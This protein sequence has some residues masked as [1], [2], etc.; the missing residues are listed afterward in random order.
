MNKKKVLLLIS[1]I[2][3]LFAFLGCTHKDDTP[4]EE[5]L[6]ISSG[7]TVTGATAKQDVDELITQESEVVFSDVISVKEGYTYGVFKDSFGMISADGKVGL[8][9]GEGHTFYVIIEK[10]GK[11]FTRKLVI[12]RKYVFT[13]SYD[14]DG[15]EGSEETFKD[16]TVGD[17]EKLT[18]PQEKPTKE[19]CTFIGWDYDFNTPIKSSLTISALWKYDEAKYTTK[20]LLSDDGND[21][22]EDEEKREEKQGLISRTVTMTA[23]A[24][25]G[26]ILDKNESTLSGVVKPDGTLELVAKYVKSLF[27]ESITVNGKEI[28]TE[29]LKT[30]VDGAAAVGQYWHYGCD[31]G[32]LTDFTSANVY[33]STD[34]DPGNNYQITKQGYA[35]AMI[36]ADRP[37]SGDVLFE[38]TAD[39]TNGPD[40]EGQKAG[41]A[42]TDG[43]DYLFVRTSWGSFQIYYGKADGQSQQVEMKMANKE[44][45]SLGT[46]HGGL[47]DKYSG[48]GYPNKAMFQ[49]EI[50]KTDGEIAVYYAKVGEAFAPCIIFTA[51]GA[52][53]PNG[54]ALPLNDTKETVAALLNSGNKILCGFGTNPKLCKT[55]YGDISIGD[56]TQ[57]NTADYKIVIRKSDNNGATWTQDGETETRQGKVGRT[58]SVVAQSKEGYVVYENESTLSGVVT[59]DGELTLTISYVRS[60]FTDSVTVNDKTVTTNR[61]KINDTTNGNYQYSIA[62]NTLTDKTLASVNSGENG[63]TDSM[64]FANTKISDKAVFEFSVDVSAAEGEKGP[65]PGTNVQGD[66]DTQRAGFALTDGT[67]YLY[68]RASYTRYQVFYSSGISMKACTNDGT[69]NIQPGLGDKYV[70]SSGDHKGESRNFANKLW[71]SVTID[72]TAKEITVY[73]A[74]EKGGAYTK[75]LMLTPSGAKG[76]KTDDNGAEISLT[77]HD[78]AKTTIGKI[79]SANEILCGF[80]TNNAPNSY[81]CNTV[82]G[83]ISIKNVETL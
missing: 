19:Y 58:V 59:A 35:S 66:I 51:D 71:F 77:A 25:N 79:L 82:F 28:T 42:L 38:F 14:L 4:K 27:S 52:K 60:L 20:I 17:G 26:Y 32:T 50:N 83:D 15:G 81:Q 1:V 76:Y 47:G 30:N 31:E 54:N 13:V 43:T 67:N 68:V 45:A 7:Y 29:Y 24:I 44:G 39:V 49:V 36:F 78:G 11:S 48:R 33:S 64:L 2:L 69:H 57:A 65:K 23:P 22:R 5:D 40:A 46:L 41:F 8:E 56:L 16:V 62:D 18:E 63:K 21:Y 75:S 53:A 74:T 9:Y 55:V 70:W 73:Y 72:K 61:L 37:R 6:Y 12:T 3:T 10:D 34:Y 80:G